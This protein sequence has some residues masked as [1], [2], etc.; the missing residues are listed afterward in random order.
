MKCRHCN[1]ALNQVFADLAF[2]PISNAMLT[3]EKLHQPERYYPLKVYVCDKC[4][5]VQV[6]EFE[7]ADKIFDS[8]YTYFSSISKTWI[9]HTKDYVDMMMERFQFDESS[10]V[11]E[12]ASNDGCLLQHFL[13]YEVPVL[14]VEP[15]ANTAKLAEDRGVKS[16]VDFFGESFVH[17]NLLNEGIQADLL[18]GNN[19]LAHVPDINDFV[20]GLKT[21]LKPGGV[22][23]IEFPHLLNLV[24]YKQFDTIYHEH[25]SYLSLS[26]VTTILEHFGLTIFDVHEIPTHGGSLRIFARHTE[27][28]ELAVTGAVKKKLNEEKDAGMLEISYYTGFQ[29]Q[30]DN[31]KYTALNFLIEEIQKGKKI[32]GYGA[33]AK[34]N[35]FLNYIG[36]KGTD[37]IKFV[38]DASPFKQGR[39]LPG[40][41]IPVVDE[42]AVREYKP[43]Y[44]II[45]PWNLKDEISDQLSYIR[46]WDARFVTFIPEQNIF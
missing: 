21:A 38:V 25:F 18:I 4:Y 12:I 7:Q 44:V 14:G 24:K 20:K 10:Q 32:I 1:N 16:I 19:V 37:L 30:I 45:L 6:D 23:T 11:I 29:N 39:F 17:E 13:E 35:T 15:T 8:D 36:V 42:E 41:H 27:N 46:D 3:E 31:I 9:R 34:G 2:S 26:A 40:S 5:L 22:I 33:A 28:T 43:D